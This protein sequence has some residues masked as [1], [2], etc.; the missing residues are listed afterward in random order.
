LHRSQ[1]NKVKMGRSVFEDEKEAHL[2]QTPDSNG[3][4]LKGLTRPNVTFQENGY[5]F[6]IGSQGPCK[7]NG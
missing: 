5:H 7:L 6:P 1:I 4:A 3:L 2:P